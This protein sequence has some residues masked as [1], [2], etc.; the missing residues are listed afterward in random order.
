MVHVVNVCFKVFFV[1][2]A[3]EAMAPWTFIQKAAYVYDTVTV[4]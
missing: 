2:N 1:F 3:R 4:S